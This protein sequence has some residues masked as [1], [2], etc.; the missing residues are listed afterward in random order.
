MA[1]KLTI[2]FS[3]KGGGALKK[4]INDLHLANIQLT[5]GQKAFVNA[6][7][8]ATKAQLKNNKAGMLG[9]KNMRIQAGAFAT[10]RS[11]LL[12][13]SFAVS[14]GTMAMAK[15]FSKFI[16]QEKAEKQLETA[17]G[18]TS[19]ALLNQA[20]ALQQITTF[21]DEAII[22]VQALIGSFT[23]D[24]EAIKSATKATLDLA[25]AKGM[26]LKA[27]GDL[28]S[29][30]LGSSTNSLSRYGVEVEGAVGSTK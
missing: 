18:K 17:L 16:E 26:D 22:G 27:G 12:L 15:L 6:Q 23:D 25:A 11:K 13:Y 19:S 4:T 20:S 21:G 30:T 8:L 10:L 7:K 9:V 14:L 24:E 1:E 5:Q 29:K 2:Q 3:A 28:V